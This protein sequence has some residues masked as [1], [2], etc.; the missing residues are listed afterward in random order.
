MNTGLPT[1]LRQVAPKSPALRKIGPLLK[2]LGISTICQSARCPNIGQCWSSGHATFLILGQ[3]CTRN[4][5]FCAVEH[6]DPLPPDP[7][8]PERV[9]AA[10][11]ALGLKHVVITSVTRDDLPD[12]G[13]SQFAAAIGALRSPLPHAAVEVLVPDFQGHERAIAV[14]LEAS[15]DIFGHNVE[16]VPRL[17]PLVRP[18][19]DYERSLRVLRIA[20]KISPGQTSKSG[21]M[22]GL[23]ETAG[24]VEQVLRDLRAA[25]VDMVTVGQYLQPTPQH[26]PV[27]EYVTPELFAHYARLAKGL[28]FTGVQSGPLVRSSYRAREMAIATCSRDP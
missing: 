8:E 13:A 7:Q 27:A 24:E 2:N 25:N 10:A 9:A 11:K 20:K 19:A 1:W 6:G 23:G 12:G 21:L 28:G 15:P 22:V 5:R 26:L 17:Y 4:C 14:V 16:T 18:A 3:R